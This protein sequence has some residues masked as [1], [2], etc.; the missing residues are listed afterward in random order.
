MTITH[1]AALRREYAERGLAEG[2]LAPDWCTQ[3]ERWLA[4][5]VAAE[6]PEPNAMVVATATP[7]G[8]PSLRT[9]LCKGY[10]ADGLLFYTNYQSRKATEL[11]ANPY[12]SLLFPWHGIERQVIIGGRAEQVDEQTSIGYFRSRPRG[13]Q[14]G[15]WSSPQSKVIPDRQVLDDAFDRYAGQWPEDTEVPRP[16]HWGGFRVRPDTV[17]FWQGRRNRAHDRLRYRRIAGSAH[18]GSAVDDDATGGWLVERL[19]P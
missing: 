19:A 1:L 6:L 5:A 14:L 18:A 8:R 11:T 15:A 16:P 12:L 10:G 3:F 4:D 7:D 9:V 2:D 13:A 17:E